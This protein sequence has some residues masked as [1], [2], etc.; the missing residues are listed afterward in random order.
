[1]ASS[2]ASAW[3]HQAYS[4]LNAAR[5]CLEERN[6]S[7][8]CQAIAKH[9]QTVEKATKAVVASLI[10]SRSTN[11]VIRFNHDIER[12][13]DALDRLPSTG[14]GIE[15]A[16]FSTYDV[17]TEGRRL[18]SLAPQG[19]PSPQGPS[20]VLLPR[21]TEYPFNNPDGTWRSPA[22]EGTFSLAEVTH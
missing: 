21:N 16:R 14:L 9:Q 8:Y 10:Q 15:V 11:L 19:I 17:G 3:Y 1:M 12:Y 22:E 13:L 5:R 6:T 18:M 7:T 20:P 2:Q 4:D